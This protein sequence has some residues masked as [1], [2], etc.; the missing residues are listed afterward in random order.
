MRP[1]PYHIQ[2]SSWANTMMWLYLELH[3]S[4]SIKSRF[5]A[6]PLGSLCTDTLSGYKVIDSGVCRGDL[7]QQLERTADVSPASTEGDGKRWESNTL[8]TL[9]APN[10]LCHDCHA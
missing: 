9:N 4:T 8:P 10:L 5:S 2:G 3:G 1:A 6:V 7:V